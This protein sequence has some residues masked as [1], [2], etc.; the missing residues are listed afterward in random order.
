[1]RSGA[2]N[3]SAARPRNENV[4]RARRLRRQREQ[5]RA[6]GHQRVVGLVGAIPFEHREFGMVQRAALA[7]AK[8]AGELED[9]PL[10]RRQQLLAGEFRRGV[11]IEPRALARR[12]RPAR[13]RRRAGAPRCRA[14][15]AGSRPRPRRSRAP[16][17]TPR[18]RHD[19]R[20]RASR[21]GRRS[22]W[23]CGAHQGEASAIACPSARP[24][25]NAGEGAQD[26]YVAARDSSGRP[27]RAARPPARSRNIVRESHRQF[28]PQRQY[29]RG[30]RQALRR[31]H[32]GKLPSRQGHADHPDR[33]APDQRRREDR[34]SATRPPTR[35]SAP[36]SRTAN[37]SSS[38]RTAT[39]S[40]S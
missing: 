14:R 21:N 2:A 17:K 1:M 27:Q 38:T 7:V 29:R 5:R 23:T 32:R 3:G 25:E 10:A 20:A 40:I 22:A 18:G 4:P 6:I 13:S 28:A 15:P 39:A 36:M 37:T 9:P 11:Q 31:P 8:H 30:R 16:R 24:R 12:A 19:A 26:Q 34:S 35:S 33:H